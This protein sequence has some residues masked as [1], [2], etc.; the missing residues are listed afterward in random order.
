VAVSLNI[1][2]NYDLEAQGISLVGKQGNITDAVDDPYNIASDTTV[3]IAGNRMNPGGTLATASV[4]LVYDASVAPLATF[5]YGHFWADQDACIQLI[6]SATEV[7]FH[8]RAKVPFVIP[9]FGKM[10]AS[11]GTSAIAGNSEPTYT[12]IAKI[13][14]G[15]YS[16]NSMN[17]ILTL[18]D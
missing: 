10:V 7:R 16:G 8:V 2:N 14:V 6:T 1:V 5:D 9:G 18:I 15:N 11:A 3:T 13:Y 4:Q 17:Y 12:T